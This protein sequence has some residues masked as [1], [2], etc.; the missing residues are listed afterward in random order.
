M[1]RNVHGL[2]L[3]RCNLDDRLA[4]AVT[5]LQFLGRR[6]GASVGHRLGQ[7]FP[8]WSEWVG[9]MRIGR[10]WRFVALDNDLTD[11]S[12]IGPIYGTKRALMA[13]MARYIRDSGY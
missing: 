9:Y 3:L 13:D 11:V 12:T 4:L 5:E 2:L 10:D 1:V 6:A 8:S 7:A